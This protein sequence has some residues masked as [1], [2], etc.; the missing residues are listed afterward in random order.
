MLLS[1]MKL[2]NIVYL[3]IKSYLVQREISHYV[4]FKL[5]VPIYFE[6]RKFQNHD[7]HSN[8]NSKPFFFF[9]CGIFGFCNFLMLE[10][11]SPK[12]KIFRSEAEFPIQLTPLRLSPCINK[13][14]SSLARKNGTIQRVK[15]LLQKELA[16]H[17][18]IF[19][20]SLLM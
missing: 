14:N 5:K 18:P 9:G 10:L 6:I 7:I 19:L 13:K 1:I 4:Q 17:R 20:L 3:I 8:S 2:L 11:I 16:C 12:L 15:A